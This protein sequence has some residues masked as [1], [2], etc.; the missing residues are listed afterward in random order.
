MGQAILYCCRCQTQL[1]SQDFEKGK[2]FRLDDKVCCLNC[3]PEVMKSLPK[4]AA[5]GVP[6]PVPPPGPVPAKAS[7]SRRIAL[8]TST[9]P[10]LSR[11]YVREPQSRP[12]ALYAALGV[13][14]TALLVGMLWLL[15][16]NRTV[17][18]EPMRA[19]PPPTPFAGRPPDSPPPPHRTPPGPDSPPKPASSEN[20]TLT[21]ARSYARANPGDLPGQLELY[22]Q[23]ERELRGTAG[24]EEAGREL[25]SLRR[26]VRGRTTAELAPI[27]ER[28]RDL[29]KKE[30]FGRA[31]GILEESRARLPDSEWAKAIDQRGEDIRRQAAALYPSMK[32]R[33]VDARRRGAQ[34]EV[35]LAQEQVSRWGLDP[36]ALDLRN[37]LSE[38]APPL[39]PE[40]AA[41]LKTWRTSAALLRA[42]DCEASSAELKRGGDLLRDAVL[43]REA[44]EDLL[45]L[46]QAGL[47]V[48]EALQIPPKWHKGQPVALE[49][50]G[51]SGVCTRVEGPVIRIDSYRAEVKSGSQARSIIVPFAEIRPASLANLLREARGKVSAPEARALALCCLLDGQPESAR[52]FLQG[53]DS[54]V[55]E[56]YWEYARSVVAASARPGGDVPPRERE[57]RSLFYSAEE[58]FEDPA[59]TAD[60]AGKYSTLLKDFGDTA[61]V[62]RNRPLL[63]LRS[64]GGGD[65]FFFP[66][67]MTAQGTF[68]L[69]KNPKTESCFTSDSDLEPGR[70]MERYV[71][72]AFSALPA[73]EYRLWVHVGACCAETFAFSYQTT[74]LV[75]V[76]G[77]EMKE[78]V[79]I[80]PGSGYVMPAKLP[81]SSLKKTHASHTGPKAPTRWEWISLPLP[82][83]AA[84]G[85]KKVRFFST[86]KGF[87]IAY[88]FVSAR[89]V[90]PPGDPE[91]KGIEKLRAETPGGSILTRLVPRS[92]PKIMIADFESDPL[93][94]TFNLGWEF[95][96]AKGSLT[97]DGTDA[98]GGKRSYRLDAD[99]TGGGAYVGTWCDLKSL[100]DRDLQELRL[101]V[102]TSTVNNIGVRVSDSTGQC[103]QAKL[104]L[105]PSKDWQEL[106]LKFEA[107]V[108]REHWSGAND[109]KW[110]GPP[111]G[112]GLNIGSGSFASATKT[113][114]LLIDDVEGILNRDRR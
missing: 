2:A 94:W 32:E 65:Y 60:A 31:L 114:S 11:A 47:L 89:K 15:G 84:S 88:A 41:Y 92:P 100:K 35:R 24:F 40:E 16:G 105:S 71:E 61:F 48:R 12:L 37:A 17:R 68:T 1:R 109:G 62:G 85:P 18:N 30:E 99:L 22:E 69:V 76:P 19:D 9:P 25:E 67:D 70:L 39:S 87:S 80:E 104:T 72:V 5:K 33:A 90:A 59:C 66:E 63:L 81:S 27:D 20:A 26:A 74:D 38:V 102:K 42:R 29:V 44:A 10:Q 108:G 55:P 56:K 111:I 43:R 21:K 6:Q 7:D 57:A 113:G 14:G 82:K 78:P 73:T 77:K 91:I 95:P 97:L 51:P 110:H 4:A 79:R 64:Q 103:H 101:W 83:Y 75:G 46:S 23:A 93:G 107:L 98:H 34:D 50:D 49:F 3:T 28:T 45:L 58:M 112:F 8:P 96:G 86:Q 53:T 13:G 52:T 54:A 36:Y 106:V